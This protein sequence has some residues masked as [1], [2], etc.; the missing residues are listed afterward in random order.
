MILFLIRII[1][2]LISIA[3]GL[4]I[5]FMVRMKID[6]RKFSV[7]KHVVYVLFS[8][9]IA[10]TFNSVLLLF[11]YFLLNVYDT[12]HES[13]V[14]KY[15]TSENKE[16]NKLIGNYLDDMISIDE[17]NKSVESIVNSRFDKKKNSD[18]VIDIDSIE[19]EEVSNVLI[20]IPLSWG[21]VLS[22]KIW[23]NFSKKA[24]DK[25]PNKSS[26]KIINKIIKHLQRSREPFSF[27]FRDIQEEKDPTVV[28]LFVM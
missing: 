11:V 23:K 6:S 4:A 3:L 5:V 8:L 26:L 1:T 19:D 25:M 17:V 9:F 24:S 15:M 28:K 27:V 16:I 21:K 12:T 14:R 20:A 10:F 18:I 22:W 2:F 7:A 13:R